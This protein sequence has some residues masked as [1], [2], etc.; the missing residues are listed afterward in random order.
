MLMSGLPSREPPNHAQR[1]APLEGRMR[2][3]E[4]WDCDVGEGRELLV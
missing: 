2:R 3:V 4:A 1:I